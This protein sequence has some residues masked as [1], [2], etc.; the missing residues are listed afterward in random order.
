MLKAALCQVPP[1]VSL[2]TADP[3]R[4]GA[5]E[6]APGNGLARQ[7]AT[8][9]DPLNMAASN[10]DLLKFGRP[11][12]DA[13]TATHLGVWSATG[14]YLYGVSLSEP[15]ALKAGIPVEMEAGALTIEEA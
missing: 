14:D 11:E 8:F 9:T 3:G 7:Q 1:F 4:T 13:G 5:N 15:T 12:K 10:K 6:V 2:H